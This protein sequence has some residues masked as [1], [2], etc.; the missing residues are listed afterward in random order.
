VKLHP[1]QQLAVEHLLKHDRAALFMGLGLGKT[2]ST[3]TAF[4]GLRTLGCARN[5]LVV[6]PLRVCNLTW[7][8]EVEKWPQFSHLKVANLR[9]KEGTKAFL[10]GTADVYLCNYEMLPKVA[11]HFEEHPMDVVVF[12]EL[13]RAKNHQSKRINGF[14]Q[15][16]PPHV[17]RWGLTG[18]PTPNSLLELFAQVRLLDDGQRLGRSFD[19]F[20]RTYFYP[21]D[22]MEYDWQPLP[23]AE[24]IIYG[25]IADLAL[26]LLSS[27]FLKIP[28]TVVTDLEVGLTDE[29]AAQYKELEKELLLSIGDGEDVIVAANAAVLVNKL[30]QVTSGSVYDENRK[31]VRLHD[32]KYKALTGYLKKHPEP[33]LIA[34]NYQHE[35]TQLREIP[36]SVAFVDYKTP[37]AQS[38]LEKLWNAG[39][40]ARLLVHPQSVGHGLNLQY[41]G[42]TVIWYSP[43]WSRELYDQLNGRVVRQG[44]TQ[45]TNIVRILCPGTIDDAVIETLREKD[46]GQRALLQALTNF[47]K[48]LEK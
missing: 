8:N 24:E 15:M 22:Y 32:A 42:S 10:E 48:L 41:G 27:D 36:G 44:Q 25:K 2:L 28:D 20:K 43:T 45:L 13:T 1:Y 6:A 26:T 33:V 3:L 9:Q 5:M 35:L 40:I 29:A 12:D 17:R 34:Y 7:P 31:V 37:K 4:E 19:H 14:R 21:T 39:K 47:R 16:L 18:T 11:D 46:V 38:E 30:L 23:G